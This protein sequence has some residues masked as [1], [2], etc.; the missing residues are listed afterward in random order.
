MTRAA[1]TP[2][3]AGRF[4]AQSERGHGELHGY[5]VRFDEI[6]LHE[7]EQLVVPARAVSKSPR[8]ALSTI[9]TISAG[10]T[11]DATEITPRPPSAING[12][13]MA[14]SPD[15]T[16]KSDGTARQISPFARCCLRPP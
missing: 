15:T 8:S 11:L 4:L 1:A 3:A 6:D 14:S 2:S 12:S 16:M 13:V 7:R 5:W 9:F 10:T